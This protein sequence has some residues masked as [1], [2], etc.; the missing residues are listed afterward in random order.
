MTRE[1]PQQLEKARA[2]YPSKKE[3][4]RNYR[5][6]SLTPVPGPMTDQIPLEI[7]SRHMK[8]KKMSQSSQH[9]FTKSK[10]CLT[11]LIISYHKMMGSVEEVGVSFG[12]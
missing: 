8:D 6:V 11:Y 9:R 10:L 7:I 5:L 4:L 12:P 2:I 1:V 3:D